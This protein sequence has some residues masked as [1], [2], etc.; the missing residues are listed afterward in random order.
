MEQPEGFEFVDKEIWH[1]DFNRA[2]IVL[3]KHLGNG[4][5]SFIF[6]SQI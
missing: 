6:Y 3:K 4:L 5:R 1:I 2:S